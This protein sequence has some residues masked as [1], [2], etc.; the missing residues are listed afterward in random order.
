MIG[1]TNNIEITA[2]ENEKIETIGIS[3]IS[4]RQ[5]IILFSVTQK[6]Q[7]LQIKNIEPMV[8]WGEVYD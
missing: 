3:N 8:E 1:T 4:S 6:D 5:E 7:V 2:L